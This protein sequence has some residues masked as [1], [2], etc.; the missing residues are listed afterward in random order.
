MRFLYTMLLSMLVTA[1]FSA[2]E[3]YRLTLR[4]NPATTIVI[5]WNQVSGSGPVV[6]YGPTDQGTNWSAYPFTQG[7]SRSVSHKGMNNHF[8]RLTGLQPNTAYYFV[9]RDSDGTS[10]RFWFK[11]APNVATERLSFIA[12]GDSRNNRTPRQNANR[13]VAKL[14]PHAVLFGGDMTDSGSNTQW[15]NWFDDWQLSI[16]SDG[17]MFPFVA[18]RGNHEGSN[19][20]IV[21]LFDVPSS[22]VY[23][24]LTFGNGLVRTYTLNTE[25]SISGSQTTWLSND[26]AAN[27]GVQ[28][29]MAQYHK[30]MRPHVSSK[31]EGNNQ[32][33][34]WAG[35]FNQY[36][37]N[38]VV[39][40]DAHTVKT[41]W[42]VV[43]STGSGSDEGFVRDDQN[44][45]V[46]VGEG[47]WG[48][49]LRSNNDGKN[50]TRN[51]GS[52]NQFKWIFVDQSKIE[53][54][55]IQVD[56]ATSVGENSN[57][58]VFATPSNL[59]I[60]NP[61]NG[62]VVTI[63]NNNVV[64]PTV[65]LTAP[66]NGAYYSAPQSITLSANAS[67]A[68]GSVDRVEF[69]VNGNL[70]GS[71]YSA[72]Y[73]VSYSIPADGSYTIGATAYDNDGNNQDATTRDINVGVV[74]QTFQKRIAAGSDDVEEEDD[75]VMYTTSSD[76]ELVADG[77]RGNQTIG[78]RFTGI[79]VPQGATIDAAYI[80]FTCDETNTG[81]TNLTIQGHDTDDAAAFSTSSYNVSNRTRTS[82]SVNWSPASWSSVGQSGSAQRT[83][84]MK[85]IV[86]EIVNRGGW[87]AGNDMVMI[88]TG[89]GERTAEAYE[90][91]AGSA[92]LLHIEYTV[93]GGTP[94]VITPPSG[95][96]AN[97]ISSTTIDLSWTDNSTGE[98]GFAIERRQGSG[99]WAQ[100]ATVASGVT[101]YSHAGLSA[102][103]SY[104]FRVRAYIG[105][106]YSS[107]SNTASATTQSGGGSSNCEV[108]SIANEGFESNF[109]IW[110]NASGDD[111]DWT[112]RSGTTPSSNTGPA[113]A[114]AGSY[115]AYME[116]S[117]PNYPSKTAN[118]ESDCLD[119]GALTDPE[120]T[121]R[122]H[123][124]GNAVG[125]LNVQVSLDGG[126]WNTVWTRSGT[127]GS[128]WLL[129]TISLTAYALES[130]VQIR[131]NG[132]TGSSWQ[133]DIV[134]DDISI[135]EAGSNPPATSGT[136]EQ[137]ILTG[138]DDVEEEDDGVMYTNSSDL[139][140]VAD[141][142]R[143][144]QTVGL[145]FTGVAVPQ[146]A[147]IDAAYIQ[148][149]SDETNSGTTNLTI[150]GHDTNDAAAF[151]TS[152]GN[153]SSR[154]RTSAS[155]S[156][157]PASWTSTG[158]TGS[159]QRTP[160][161]KSIVQEIV[162]RSGWNSGNDMVMIITGT[163]E[164]TAD[165]YE[166][167]ANNAP[168]LHIEYT[169]GG[170][171]RR[172]Q[173]AVELPSSVIAF[174]NPSHGAIHIQAPEGWNG[175]TI[176]IFG[177]NGQ[178][179]WNAQMHAKANEMT[180]EGHVLAAGIYLIK[181]SNGTE[182]QIL[183]VVKH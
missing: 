23:Y 54:R 74:S 7:V 72:P 168:L 128:N 5:G 145:R 136:W 105:T 178:R 4:D 50:W 167:G 177:L 100:I 140:L 154:T 137:R 174:P 120:L 86:Q 159:A 106:D 97:A 122:Y 138:M 179:I 52:F 118:L 131:F 77:S 148:F 112:R 44:G 165:S 47:C 12:G 104:D 64:L 132:T 170:S 48:A 157:N 27:N 75:G 36:N 173:T 181:V 84:E 176:E 146:G 37:V 101:S 34:Y 38:L 13:L 65:A 25:M 109:G 80:Q 171:A 116:A 99:S 133:G 156:W 144:N 16:A 90:G 135:Q 21:N 182:S 14:K 162:N 61:S 87:S 139:E 67:D 51:S 121:F 151:T 1:G 10:Q 71:D 59:N 169:V 147:I 24:A 53:V 26:L 8:A 92:P 78:L 107:Y 134:I 98:D 127:Q 58:N 108:A 31:S 152:N 113:S 158:A 22:N 18:T 66:S 115:Y 175:S 46:Y 129:A 33:N 130:D 160:E 117:S 82:A 39:E 45:T 56:N 143:G 141:G 183:K 40:C 119:F 161:M 103:T 28:W 70:V 83:P 180:I 57:N 96:T 3:K 153:V 49:P 95:L 123:M 17:R 60:W 11:T 94:V 63:L 29:K 76:I 124:L 55:T 6:Y 163:G 20:D 79:S 30:P 85:S 102:S 88:L 43:P 166:G 164:R 155:V 35:L 62:S 41:T 126:T 9:I 142:N 91:S 172:A 32:Y 93:G 114:Y 150:Q 42:P 73:S 89:T 81:T 111:M 2:T 110:N 69:F 19:T 68:D 149:R 125:T 15:D